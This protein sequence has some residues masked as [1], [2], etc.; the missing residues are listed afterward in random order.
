[1][2][3]RTFGSATLLLVTAKF[4]LAGLLHSLEM[5]MKNGSFFTRVHVGLDNRSFIPYSGTG[6]NI[7]FGPVMNC[8]NC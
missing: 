4:V 8:Y 7:Y 2:Q 5:S 1:M 6:I 3:R